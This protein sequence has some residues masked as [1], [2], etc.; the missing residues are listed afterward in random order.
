V[1][2]AFEAKEN[3]SRNFALL[4]DLVAWSVPPGLPDAFFSNQKS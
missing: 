1:N 4:Y 3:R 2:A